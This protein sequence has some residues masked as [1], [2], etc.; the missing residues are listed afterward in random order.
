MNKSPCCNFNTSMTHGWT[1]EKHGRFCP[2]SCPLD[3]KEKKSAS[4]EHCVK[5]TKELGFIINKHL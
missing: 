3:C 2:R 1:C 5:C 4:F